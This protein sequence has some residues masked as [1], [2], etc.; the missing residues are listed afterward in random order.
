MKHAKIIKTKKEDIK[1]RKENERHIFS[2]CTKNLYTLYCKLNHKGRYWM[3][4]E[5]KINELKEENPRE[6]SHH[7][8]HA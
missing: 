8:L 7:L 2:F 5:A 1:I 3:R 6:K 4:R